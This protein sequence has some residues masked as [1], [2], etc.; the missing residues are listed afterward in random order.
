[1]IRKPVKCAFFFKLIETIFVNGSEGKH[2]M[3]CLML[4]HPEFTDVRDEVFFEYV[5]NAPLG[6][7]VSAK[8][9][10]MNSLS[11]LFKLKT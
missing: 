10:K 4:L 11:R 9:K 2:I 8:L 7:N 5:V 3:N 1:M 6:L